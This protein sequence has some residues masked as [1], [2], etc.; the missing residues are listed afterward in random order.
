[1]RKNLG[2]LLLSTAAVA[3]F[4]I[5]GVPGHAAAGTTETLTG[6]C[7]SGPSTTTTILDTI[8][9]SVVNGTVH[10]KNVLNDPATGKTVTFYSL[11]K[12]SSVDES[13]FWTGPAILV[14][15]NVQGGIVYLTGHA[16]VGFSGG[17]YP[18][19]LT[20]DH[21]FDVCA[22]VFGYSA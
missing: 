4:G 14:F 7:F 18:A 17:G 5:V 1:V 21:S 11:Y 2:R 13:E 19:S 20:A 8:T 9:R 3:L 12:V 16:S 10:E 15:D 22:T 6:F